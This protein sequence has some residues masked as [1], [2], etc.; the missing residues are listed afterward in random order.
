[1]HKTKIMTL[2]HFFVTKHNRNSKNDAT[3]RQRKKKWISYQN[4]LEAELS[5][6]D[7][8]ETIIC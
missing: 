3:R 7:D 2:W 6:L 1:M 4:P 8:V 5:D